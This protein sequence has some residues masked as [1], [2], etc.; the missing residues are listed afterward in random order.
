MTPLAS[1][2]LVVQLG[3]LA[4]EHIDA[5]SVGVLLGDPLPHVVN[6]IDTVMLFIC[7]GGGIE[8]V[9]LHIDTVNELVHAVKIGV[10]GN[11]E[12]CVLRIPGQSIYIIISDP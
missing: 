9:R 2:G 5:V 8:A 4:V 12:L 11:G 6:G 3:L 7:I 1:A 10:G